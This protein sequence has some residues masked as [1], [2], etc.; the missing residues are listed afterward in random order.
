MYFLKTGS[1]TPKEVSQGPAV[2]NCGCAAA[3]PSCHLSV[4]V[5]G[6]Q[7]AHIS[8]RFYLCL[9]NSGWIAMC[10]VV[11]G[12]MG[13]VN[14]SCWAAWLCAVCW[15]DPLLSGAHSETNIVLHKSCSSVKMPVKVH[16]AH[17][18]FMLE[19]PAPWAKMSVCI[20]DVW[21]C[22]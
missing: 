13:C 7:C 2:V 10:C 4:L 8:V 5:S 21:M 17:V 11:I 20:D 9:C 19:R 16:A 6:W 1:F 22:V 14:P 15:G 12:A 18:H 3:V